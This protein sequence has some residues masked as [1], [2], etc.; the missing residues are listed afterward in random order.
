MTSDQFLYRADNVTAPATRCFSI[1]PDDIQAIP[2]SVKAIYI[3]GGGDVVLR[4][5]HGAVD[6][7]FKAVPQGSTLDVRAIAVRATGTTATHLVGLA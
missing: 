7:T 1:V 2:E 3:G 6:V 5:L 4:P